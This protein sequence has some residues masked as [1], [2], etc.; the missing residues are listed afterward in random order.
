M[1][2]WFTKG[3]AWIVVVAALTLGKQAV[4]QVNT[5]ELTGSTPGLTAGSFSISSAGLSNLN[6]LNSAGS[7]A[8]QYYSVF[9]TP[10]STQQYKFGQTFSSVDTVMFISTAEFNPSNPGNGAFVLND[11]TPQASHQS[12]YGSLPADFGCGTTSY[13]PQISADLE[14]GKTYSIVVTTYGGSNSTTLPLPQK[15]YAVGPGTFTASAPAPTSPASEFAAK[16]EDIKTEIVSDVKANLQNV[17]SANVNLVKQAKVRFIASQSNTADA[18]N[19]LPGRNSVPLNYDATLSADSTRITSSG[20]FFAQQGSYDGKSRQVV[21]G[22]FSVVGEKDGSVTGTL[23]SRIARE[24]HISDQTMMGYFLGVEISHTDIY[25]TFT[26]KNRG[27]GLI[28]GGYFVNELTDNVFVD[29]FVSV[30]TG[31]NILEMSDDVLSLEG[32]YQT[33]SGSIGG[34]LTGVYDMG[35]YEFWPELSFAVGKTKTLKANFTG[36]AYGQVDDSLTLDTDDTTIAK[37]TVRPE[38]R[39]DLEDEYMS[40]GYT[41][42]LTMAPR[43]ICEWVTTDRRTQDCGSGAE[44][45]LMRR[46][47]D[48]LSQ[49][50][51]TISRDYVGS[52]GRTGLEF[53]FEK[54]F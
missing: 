7:V 44:V 19:F 31:N 49:F 47:Y 26:G 36:T 37:L 38:M 39:R 21:F 54:R 20:N 48:G 2:N 33:R 51:A 14:A 52:S 13:C 6:A 43:L 28:M 3:M 50:T 18:M 41:S 40:S 12:A 45:G 32:I 30:G 1:S 5:I 34:A 25:S 35:T 23:S 8:R 11:D 22:D 17:L 53:K 29:G 16:K 15:F 10:S 42:Q 24:R 9:F 4:A 46:S 27:Y